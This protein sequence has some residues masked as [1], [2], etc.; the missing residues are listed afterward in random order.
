MNE[1]E[2][3][4]QTGLAFFGAVAASI[5]HEIKNRMAIINEQAGLLEDFVLIAE[6][7]GQIDLNRLKRLSDSVKNQ[8]KKSDHIIK[9]M[10]RFAHSVDSPRDRVEVGPLIE[11]TVQLAARTADQKGVEL[12]VDTGAEKA[13]L[14]TAPF[15]L[16]NLVW[17]SIEA[18][19]AA[20]PSGSAVFLGWEK[21]PDAVNIRIYGRQGE[22]TGITP[23][24]SPGAFD[25][26]AFLG[27]EFISDPS[28]E[29]TAIRI[30]LDG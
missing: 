10:N 26:A 1:M 27:A 16:M 7:G 24:D 29:G 25:L 11:L 2:T 14:T 9:N 21:K 15:L 23:P 8:V 12:K 6:K 30:P 19:L 20:S 28:G 18:A 22:N 17:L 5:S 13:E 3:I 4:G